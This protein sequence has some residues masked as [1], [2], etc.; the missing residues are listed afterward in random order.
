M[1][2]SFF[3]SLVAVVVSVAMAATPIAT[4][5][6]GEGLKVRGTP[7]PPTAVSSWPVASGDELASSASPAVVM[8]KDQSRLTLSPSSRVKLE[9]RGDNVCIFLLD[10]SLRLSAVAG[11]QIGVGGRGKFLVAQTPFEGQVTLVEPNTLKVDAVTGTL[12]AGKSPCTDSPIFAAMGGKTAAIVIITAAAVGTV[13]GIAVT[14]GTDSALSG[15][16]TP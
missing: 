8:F 9:Q 1:R 14:R 6:S 11:A 5:V 16:T 7:V 4:V 2:N 13:T 12:A 10:G 3:I 15:S